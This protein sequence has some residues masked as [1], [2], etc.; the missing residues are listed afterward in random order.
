MGGTVYLS[1]S[2]D[3]SE[4]AKLPKN[5]PTTNIHSQPMRGVFS[6]KKLLSW[7]TVGPKLL[8]PRAAVVSN[9]VEIPNGWSAETKANQ[10]NTPMQAPT[11]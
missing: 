9:A 5:T 3:T 7:A 6:E 4:L 10:L 11:A 8:R 1:R 2:P